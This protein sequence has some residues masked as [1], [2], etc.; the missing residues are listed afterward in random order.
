MHKISCWSL[1]NPTQLLAVSW[2]SQQL[3]L[4]QWR[5]EV[6]EEGEEGESEH[7]EVGE[8]GKEMGKCV[9]GWRPLQGAVVAMA[10]DPTSTLLATGHTLVL[11]VF[12]VHFCV[13]NSVFRFQ[14]WNQGMG[15]CPALLHTQ[16]QTIWRARGSADLSPRPRPPCS[17][18][19]HRLRHF[20]KGES[21][22]CVCD[23][24]V[25]LSL[26]VCVC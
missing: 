26:C 13:L 4:Y 22:L 2:R 3:K 20:D 1:F 19:L 24:R 16:P 8:D 21:E 14:C 7:R 5:V 17:V 9:R 10:I 12:C 6:G 15:L 25:C 23:V 11:L 18:L